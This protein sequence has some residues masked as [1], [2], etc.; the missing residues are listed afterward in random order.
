[1]EAILDPL[2]K[3]C[4]GDVNKELVIDCFDWNKSGK[5]D[6]IGQS[7]RL[8]LHWLLEAGKLP[9]CPPEKKKKKGTSTRTV[10]SFTSFKGR[11]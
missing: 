11:L 7:T 2:A 4:E 10:A 5:P 9:D 8:L 1:L 6:L 3:L